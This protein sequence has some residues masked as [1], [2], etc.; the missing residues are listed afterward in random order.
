M[1]LRTSRPRQPTR[2]DEAGETQ[3]LA[4]KELFRLVRDR[5]P[6]YTA[7]QFTDMPQKVHTKQSKVRRV[8]F[9]LLPFSIL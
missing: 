4:P 1:L 2:D 7:L 6:D 8:S 5:H 9:F 3:P